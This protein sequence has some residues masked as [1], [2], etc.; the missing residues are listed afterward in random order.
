M[1]NWLPSNFCRYSP[2][3]LVASAASRME[4]PFLLAGVLEAF[5]DGL[6]GGSVAGFQGQGKNVLAARAV[7]G[8]SRSPRISRGLEPFSGPT[9]PFSSMISMMRAARL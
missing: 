6:H 9:M 7:S 2:R 8:A 5:S 1:S 4:M 3:I